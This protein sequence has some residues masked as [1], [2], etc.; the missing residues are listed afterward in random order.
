MLFATSVLAYYH[1]FAGE[2]VQARIHLERAL[3]LGRAIGA[4]R[5]VASPLVE[6]GWLCLAE[7]SWDEASR[8]LEVGR[9]AAEGGANVR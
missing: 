1:F 8:Y 6:L 2:W 4:P 3:A 5:V 9:S 7:G